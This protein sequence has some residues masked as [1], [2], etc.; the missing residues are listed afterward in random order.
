FFRRHRQIGFKKAVKIA[1]R[2]GRN[3]GQS[4]K[5]KG[6]IYM[7]FDVDQNSQNRLDVVRLNHDF[8]KATCSS[9]IEPTP[10]GTAPSTRSSVPFTWDACS[11]A[12]KE[13]A[14]A[15]F[16]GGIQA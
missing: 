1:R 2:N 7:G 3:G 14:V 13:I 12:K 16:S 9:K 4:R 5:R 15:T 10:T 8:L 6:L 11:E